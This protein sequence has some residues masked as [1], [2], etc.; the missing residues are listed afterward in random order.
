MTLPSDDDRLVEFLRRHRPEPPSP[1]SEL[2]DQLM[3]AIE[4]SLPSQEVARS[5]RHLP[6]RPYRYTIPAI[7]ASVLLVWGGWL[8]WRIPLSQKAELA[9][10]DD[11]LTATWYG[12]AFGD[13]AYRLTLD[14]TESD[15]FLSVYA[16]PY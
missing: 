6:S 4:E 12:S 14:T 3:A 7:A 13:D 2:E 8:S 1:P 9:T 16:T 5:R 10:V 11:F 15:W